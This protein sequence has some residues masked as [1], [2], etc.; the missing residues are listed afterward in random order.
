MVTPALAMRIR[1]GTFSGVPI[2]SLARTPP[3][4]AVR[5]TELSSSRFN[6]F[7]RFHVIVGPFGRL[8]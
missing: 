8:F 7:G 3:A 6:E 2:T 4:N 1:L 5:Y